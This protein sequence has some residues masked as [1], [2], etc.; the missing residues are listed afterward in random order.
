MSLVI[1]S[2]TSVR[3][4]A[5]VVRHFA[6]TRGVEV[7]ALQASPLLGAYL[8]GLALDAADVSRLGLLLLGSSAL[9]AHVFVFNDWAGYS[10][11]AHD[12]RRTSLG[13][14]GGAI[15]RD[16]IAHVAVA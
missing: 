6:S 7:C 4:Y 1:A 3:Q 11:D 12:R 10:S 15:S 5:R 13:A 9:T 16:Q 8:G 2:Q 14:G